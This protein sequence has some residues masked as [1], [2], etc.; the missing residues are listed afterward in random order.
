ML[1]KDRKMNKW[2]YF[3]SGL[4][5]GA[6]SGAVGYRTYRYYKD[7]KEFE[8]HFDE[9]EDISEEYLRSSDEVNPET[10]TGRENGSIS[11]QERDEIRR[12]LQTNHSMTTNYAEM[13]KEHPVDSDEDEDSEEPGDEYFEDSD[14]EE[15]LN[16]AEMNATLEHAK[17]KNKPPKII[18]YDAVVDLPEYIEQCDLF[19]YSGD[20]VLTNEG[21][22][23]LDPETFIGDALYKYNF[24]NNDETEIYVMNYQFDTCYCVTKVNSFF[25]DIKEEGGEDIE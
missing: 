15:V 23:E 24:A 18:S 3:V 19:Y 10:N 1:R 4:V 16:E 21:E 5:L 11:S 8:D 14:E 7:R 22:E 2:L 25:S 17:N 6:I 13:Y 12:K 20:G 9:Y